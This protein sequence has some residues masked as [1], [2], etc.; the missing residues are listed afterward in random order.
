MRLHP[1]P[2]CLKLLEAGVLTFSEQLAIYTR[3]RTR[4]RMAGALGSL[5]L[6]AADGVR[7]EVGRECGTGAAALRWR[8]QCFPVA[9]TV[10]RS[11]PSEDEY[12]AVVGCGTSWQARVWRLRGGVR[13]GVGHTGRTCMPR[14]G[15]R[16]RAAAVLVRG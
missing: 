2:G 8:P 13:W 1:R 6:S 9:C 3:F 16:R 5:E 15:L 14:C 4:P 10:R 12:E 11:A 7:K